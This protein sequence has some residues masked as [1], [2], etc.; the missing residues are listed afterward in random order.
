MALNDEQ[1]ASMMKFLEDK[2]KIIQHGELKEGDFVRLAELGY[3]NGGVVLKVEHK[4]SH[5]IMARKV[6]VCLCERERGRERERD[7]ERERAWKKLS[8]GILKQDITKFSTFL[9]FDVSIVAR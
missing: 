3:G 1:R 6:C 2:K 8:V 4:P 7:R 9:T 5:I